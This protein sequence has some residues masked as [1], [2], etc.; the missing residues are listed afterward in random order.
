MKENC[1]YAQWI[2]SSDGYYPFCSKCKYW[3]PYESNLSRTCPNC[4]AEMIN[5]R[6]F[7][8]RISHDNNQ[9]SV[10]ENDNVL[11]NIQM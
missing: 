7:N 10:G 8:K 4:K 2:I 3:L 6:K 9:L 5:L 1:N 11:C